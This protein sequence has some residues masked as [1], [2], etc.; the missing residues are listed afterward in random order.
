MAVAVLPLASLAVQVTV[1]V[2]VGKVAGALFVTVASAQL[3]AVVGVPKLIGLPKQAVKAGGAVIVGMILSVTVT[4]KE[5]VAVL[6]IPS[7]AK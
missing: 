5:Q 2:P 3:S 4:V 1:V 6:P 7:V